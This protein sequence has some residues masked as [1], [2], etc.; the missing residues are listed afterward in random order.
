[1]ENPMALINVFISAIT[2]N[3]ALFEQLLADAEREIS[4]V[5][6]RYLRQSRMMMMAGSWWPDSHTPDSTLVIK[7]TH[8]HTHTGKGGGERLPS[9]GPDMDGWR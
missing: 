6:N 2:I 3:W 4:R 5:G 1:M 9:S 7:Q 8:T